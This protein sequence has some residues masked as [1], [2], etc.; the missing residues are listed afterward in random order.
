[1]LVCAHCGSGSIIP[2]KEFVYGQG[3]IERPKCLKCGREKFE[4]REN[5]AKIIR[6]ELVERVKEEAKVMGNSGKC[7]FEGC[8]KSRLAGGYCYRHY[9]EVNGHPY[10]GGQKNHKGGNIEMPEKNNQEPIPLFRIF[11]DPEL[12]EKLTDA[13]KREYRTP[14]LHAAWLIDKALQEKAD[15]TYQSGSARRGG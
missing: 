2:E 5:P 7:K 4:E 14:E 15:D 8:D 13:A 6:T 3:W 1:V 12:L 10:R 9:K 11:L